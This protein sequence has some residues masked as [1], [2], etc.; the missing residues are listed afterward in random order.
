MV[1]SAC[2]SGDIGSMQQP[3]A[4]RVQTPDGREY[5][6]VSVGVV[7]EWAR[8]GRVTRDAVLIGEDG[9]RVGVMTE[10]QIAAIFRAP[11][12][13]PR[14]VPHAPGGDET[15][16]TLVPYRNKPALI[17]Y[18]AAIVGALLAIILPMVGLAVSA[19]GGP[20]I[21]LGAF[22]CL[23]GIAAPVSAIVLGVKGRRLSI[24][25]PQAH[26]R[27]HA[28]IGILGGCF[29]AVLA[30]FFTVMFVVMLVHKP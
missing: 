6:P 1:D 25:R 14:P 4:Y 10:P 20:A 16:A 15:L 19:A 12:T 5:G 29:G 23:L 30:M 13:T 17:G 21:V 26:G 22:M 7:A 9:V 27:V 2:H 24:E 3:S 8:Q 28:W 11:P 18:Y